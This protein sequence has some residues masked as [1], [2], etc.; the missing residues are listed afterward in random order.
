M[1]LWKAY[2]QLHQ[3]EAAFRIPGALSLRPICISVK[4]GAGPHPG[5]FLA[6]VLWKTLELWQSARVGQLTAYLA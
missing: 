3:A 4:I 2:I 1:T 6:F 5:V